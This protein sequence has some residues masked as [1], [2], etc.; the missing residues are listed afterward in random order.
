MVLSFPI[1]VECIGNGKLKPFVP[2]IATEDEPVGRRREVKAPEEKKKISKEK[3][4]TFTS[5]LVKS[6][7]GVVMF[8]GC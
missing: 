6:F 1:T 8:T 7:G 5:R 4:Q 3:C 2:A